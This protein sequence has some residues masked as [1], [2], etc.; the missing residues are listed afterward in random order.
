MWFLCTTI[1][2][3]LWNLPIAVVAGTINPKKIVCK[4]RDKKP[5]IQVEQCKPVFSMKRKACEKLIRKCKCQHDIEMKW[6]GNGCPGS[7]GD[8]VRFYFKLLGHY[9]LT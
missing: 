9:T 2:L 3:M 6:T 7:Q 1:L 5:V 4:N 8:G